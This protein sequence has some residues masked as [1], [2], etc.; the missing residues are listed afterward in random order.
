VTFNK[1][2]NVLSQ[3][4]EPGRRLTLADYISV[5]GIFSADR[6]DYDSEGLLVQTE[7]GR[8]K[9]R[10]SD[11]HAGM[12]YTYWVQME[13]VITQKAIQHFLPVFCWMMA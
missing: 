10:I 6:L 1:P 11:P 2:F 12:S 13:G 9:R 8:I 4:T 3:F 5:P 7:I